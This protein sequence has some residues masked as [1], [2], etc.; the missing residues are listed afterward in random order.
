M[1]AKDAPVVA[2]FRYRDDGSAEFDRSRRASAENML[3]EGLG[4]RRRHRERRP[5]RGCLD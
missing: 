1:R 3:E 4:D 2:L 5:T